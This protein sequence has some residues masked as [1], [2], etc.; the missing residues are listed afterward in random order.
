MPKMNSNVRKLKSQP[1]LTPSEVQRIA[2]KLAV[3]LEH[4]EGVNLLTML[5]SHLQAAAD[6]KSCDLEI[7]IYDVKRHLFHGTA[8]SDSAQQKFE[9]DSF[10]NRGKLLAWPTERS[11]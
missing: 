3:A 11:R 10:A 2:E 6:N 5:F 8:E 9:S 1:K 7:A 4:G